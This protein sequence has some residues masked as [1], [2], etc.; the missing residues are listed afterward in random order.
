MKGILVIDPE[1]C[2]GCRTCEIICSF[3]HTKEVSPARARLHIVK[4]EKEGI[5]V[6]MMCQ[7]CETPL[8][9]EVCSVKGAIY[10]DPETGAMLTNHDLCIGCRFCMLA[11]PFGG[12]S[13][14]PEDG[15][16]IKC[17]LCGGDPMCAKW[18]SKEAIQ[19]IEADR[20]SMLRKRTGTQKLAKFLGLILGG[21]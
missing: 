21:E 1:K 12:P 19:Y 6:P 14:D 18:C 3:F 8:C 7:Q 13:V 5:D 20:V 2:T 17:D 11:C 9:Q 16:T 15:L 4:W 10:R